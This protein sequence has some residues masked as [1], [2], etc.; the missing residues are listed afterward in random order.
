[1]SSVN[2]MDNEQAVNSC[3]ERQT[4]ITTLQEIL[5]DDKLILLL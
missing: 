1:M 3:G 5:G 2:L 4:A